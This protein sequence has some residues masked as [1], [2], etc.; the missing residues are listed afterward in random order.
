MKALLFPF[1]VMW[2]AVSRFIYLVSGW[3][4]FK[5]LLGMET[6]QPDIISKTLH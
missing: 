6:G 2:R 4:L 5:R 1:Y 3:W